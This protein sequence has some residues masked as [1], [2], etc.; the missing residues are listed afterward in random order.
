MFGDTLRALGIPMLQDQQAEAVTGPRPTLAGMTSQDPTRAPQ[1]SRAPG[2]L[3]APRSWDAYAQTPPTPRERQG[4]MDIFIGGGWDNILPHGVMKDY[5][6]DYATQTGRPT[7][8]FPNGA[9]DQVENAIR[10]GVA[11]GGPVNVVGHSW[12]GPDA[13]NAV[14]RAN[15]DGLPVAN[16]VT[17]DP[18]GG[19]SRAVEGPVHPGTWMNVNAAPIHPDYTDWIASFPLLA[20][21][22]SDLPV[23][24]ADEP[25]DLQLNHRD[26]DDMMRRSGARALL[27]GSRQLDG[28]GRDT[29]AQAGQTF[30][31]QGLQDNLPMMDWIRQREAELQA[32]Q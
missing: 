23:Q 15:R 7:R 30:A 16:L 4:G 18:V 26:V 8:Y 11:N 24:Q 17:L 19:P 32:Q 12:G 21:K 2:L 13:Y 1:V 6:K 5:A 22:P 10:E 27:D 31:A 9:V 25:V 3:P 28:A 14:A 29:G 20:H